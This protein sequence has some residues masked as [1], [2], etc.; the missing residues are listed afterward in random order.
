KPAP[1]P[2]P[3]PASPT[4]A[5][6][7]QNSPPAPAAPPTPSARRATAPTPAKTAPARTER[8]VRSARGNPCKFSEERLLLACGAKADE[9][10]RPARRIPRKRKGAPLH[11]KETRPE[12]PK[13]HLRPV[14]PSNAGNSSSDITNR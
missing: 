12:F 10:P 9:S 11:V 7:P 1:P 14:H 13:K 3:P 4:I 5:T 6:P 2:A 8:A